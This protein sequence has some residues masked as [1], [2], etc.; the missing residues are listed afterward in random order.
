MLVEIAIGDAY[1]AGMEYADADFVRRHNTVSGYVAHPRHQ[2]G[3]GRYTDDA[4]MTIAVTEVL[5]TRDFTAQRFADAFVSCFKRD[6]RVGYAGGF[7]KFLCS[8]A[9]GSD[10]IAQIKPF[11]DKSGGAMRAATL[12]ILPDVETVR[13]VSTMQAALTHNTTDGINAAVAAS[14]TA[15]YFLYGL[16]AKRDLG[17]FL[18]VHVPGRTWS[19]PWRE[20]V[21]EKG[22]QS[23]HA[24]VSAII[25]SNSMTELLRTCI[26]YTGDVDTVAAVAMGAAAACS[27]IKKDTPKALID[28]LENG[29]Y[30]RRYL[31]DLDAQ[32]AAELAYYQGK[33]K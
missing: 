18:E 17:K 25:T 24:A 16:G 8:V 3:L 10:F 20:P 32:L 14:L 13:R 29:A 26:G 21:G 12:G 22:W 2:I 4:Q 23:V 28:G 7:Y 19:A 1:G 15:H 31:L 5:L 27:E 30:G 11:S 33:C 9:D 6:Q